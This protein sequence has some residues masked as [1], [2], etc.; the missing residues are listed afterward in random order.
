M[1]VHRCTHS[2]TAFIKRRRLETENC[3]QGVSRTHSPLFELWV[4]QPVG[5]A[6]P[7]NTDAFQDSAASQLI[8]DQVGIHHAC[9]E[10]GCRMGGWGHC[11]GAGQATPCT[12]G[13][14]QG[15]PGSPQ[16]SHGPEVLQRVTSGQVG[17][18]L[19]C[20]VARIRS[21]DGSIVGVLSG[22]HVAPI[23]LGN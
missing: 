23:I 2:G 19:L 18:P 15:V 11:P 4:L 14:P 10:G 22:P 16:L 21:L 7:A 12:Q 20:Q 8:H 3:T 17:T 5:E 9:Q 6:L 13:G 1:S